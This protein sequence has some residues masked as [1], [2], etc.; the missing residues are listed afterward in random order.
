MGY[1]VLSSANQIEIAESF[2]NLLRLALLG[3]TQVESQRPYFELTSKLLLISTVR[4]SKDF[5]LRIFIFFL[6]N[7][8]KLVFLKK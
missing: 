8:L 1:F 6:L 3:S 5:F 4:V 7:V 2:L